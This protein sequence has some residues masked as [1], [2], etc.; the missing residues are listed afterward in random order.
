MSL[1]LF[2]V[3]HGETAWNA[4][5]RYQ[6]QTDVPLSAAGLRQ[7][8]AIA[9]RLAMTPLDAIYASDLCRAAETAHA[10]ARHH[11]LDVRLDPRWREM[12]FGEWHGLTYPQME[13]AF[14]ETVA[15][16]NADRVHHAPPGG[17]TLA[18]LAA[19]VHAALDDIRRAHPEQTVLIASHGGA[20]RAL[21][22][23]LLHKSLGDYW[24]FALGNTSLTEVEFQRIGP[25]LNRLNDMQHLGL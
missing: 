23:L 10:I 22:C 18:Q 24:Q 20:I 5:G 25:V 16:W 6:G 8:E 13:A 12:S 14:P 17:E 21:L 19:R 11:T 3:R 7:A 4:E 2:L 15:W 9:G 1:R